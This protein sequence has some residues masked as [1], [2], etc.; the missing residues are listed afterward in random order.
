VTV[1]W[2][3]ANGT[4]LHGGKPDCV[5]TPRSRR[6]GTSTGQQVDLGCGQNGQ[7]G[8]VLSL[9]N[10]DHL[11]AA[12]SPIVVEQRRHVR[13]VDFNG[14]VSDLAWPIMPAATLTL[15]LAMATAHRARRESPITVGNKLP[16]P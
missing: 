5:A 16:V 12:G 6:W 9:G 15:L 2:A 1:L 13:P 3:M 10:G 7:H 11:Y 4:S 14:T 8:T